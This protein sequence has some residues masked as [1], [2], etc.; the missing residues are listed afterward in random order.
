MGFLQSISNSITVTISS[1]GVWGDIIVN[2]FGVIAI[3]SMFIGYQM[4]QRQKIFILYMIANVC[5]VFYFTLQGNLVS[6]LMCLIS[7]I[8]SL[9]FLQRGK[10]KWAESILWLYFFL[11]VMLTSTVLTYRD[12]R[13]IFAL[14][15]T[16]FGT[17]AFFAIKEKTLRIVNSGAYIFWM[18]NSIT[19]LYWVALISDTISF[20]SLLIA[21]YRYRKVEPT[22][23][24]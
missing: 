3:I 10:K 8:R 20:I 22:K 1:I 12:W 14:L 7:L 5:W 11:A 24:E 19:N 23:A 9:V 18:V 16:A 13:D 17:I 21:L 2:L 4:K 15:A 6:A